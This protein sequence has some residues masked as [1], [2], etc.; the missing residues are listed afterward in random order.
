MGMVYDHVKALQTR[1]F[2]SRQMQLVHGVRGTMN[3]RDSSKIE[4]TQCT[5]METFLVCWDFTLY[6]LKFEYKDF[7]LYRL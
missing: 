5:S 3:E 4:V 6:L 1:I 2:S 7:V